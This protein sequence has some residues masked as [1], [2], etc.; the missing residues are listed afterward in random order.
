LTCSPNCS[1]I[2]INL[3]SLYPQTY[4][5]PHPRI[6]ENHS[7]NF[8]FVSPPLP[9][10]DSSQQSLGLPTLRPNSIALDVHVPPHN[11][12]SAESTTTRWCP[13]SYWPQTPYCPSQKP[14]GADAVDEHVL[15]TWHGTT[16]NST[17]NRASAAT[18][19]ADSSYPSAICQH[20]DDSAIPTSRSRQCIQSDA[21]ADAGHGT[22]ER[23]P[24]PKPNAT[25][26]AAAATTTIECTYGCTYTTSLTSS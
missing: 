12:A 25:T 2:I 9:S 22:T 8:A 23:F 3:L 15:L 20:G 24:I 1:L 5:S 10:F 17:A 19:T 14:F 6:L 4:T 26:T 11:G 18:A 16:C 7:F 13:R 21:A